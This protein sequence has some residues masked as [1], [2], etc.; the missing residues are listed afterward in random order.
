M[1]FAVSVGRGSRLYRTLS[2]I[3]EAGA[4][5]LGQA[6]FE[7]GGAGFD[8]GE[9]EVLHR[10]VDGLERVVVGWNLKVALG[11]GKHRGGGLAGWIG[12]FGRR[13]DRTWTSKRA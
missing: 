9:E 1:F 7:S 4:T 13:G 3:C 6:E 10:H 2:T 12:T 5:L 11:T 8:R